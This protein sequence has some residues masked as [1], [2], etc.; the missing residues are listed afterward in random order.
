MSSTLFFMI[1]GYYSYDLSGRAIGNK[2]K[3]TFLMVLL[4]NTLYFIWDIC[5]EILFG[6]PIQTWFRANCSVKRVI[7]WIMTNESPFRGHLWFL[8]AL[9]YAYLFLYFVIKR[10]EKKIDGEG[11]RRD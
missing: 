11:M 4:A 10:E 2:V 1:S 7:V 3:R 9:L 6:K 5:V 8:G